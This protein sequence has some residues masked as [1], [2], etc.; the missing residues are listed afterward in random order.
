MTRVGRND[1]PP[2][3]NRAGF[4][5]ENGRDRRGGAR[6]HGMLAPPR[7]G[8]S[9]PERVEPCAL[10]GLRHAHSLVERLHAELQNTDAEGNCH[11]G[12]VQECSRPFTSAH[13]ARFSGV[14]TPTFSPQCT[15]APFMKSISV[16]RR[17]RT[18]CSMLALCLPGAFAPFCTSSR[19]S[20]CKLIPSAFATARPSSIKSLNSCPVGTKR[21]AAP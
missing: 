14:A 10:A 2:D 5:R 6:F 15:I 18:S 21:V 8:L 4:A 11:H 17:A 12:S 1:S 9:E 20:P 7:I 16:C 3:R 19:G 13:I